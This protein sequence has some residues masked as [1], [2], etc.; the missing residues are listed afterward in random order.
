MNLALFASALVNIFGLCIVVGLIFMALDSPYI[1]LDAWMKRFAKFAVGGAACLA[2]II[3][4][5]GLLGIGGGASLMKATPESILEFA[6]GVLLLLAGMYI[7]EFVVAWLLG[8][9]QT[10]PGPALPFAPNQPQP[11]PAVTPAMPAGLAGILIFVL[12]VI[13]IVLILVLAERALFAGGLGIIPNFTGMHP[14]VR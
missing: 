8:G 6:I 3:Y 4:C 12:N 10:V 7:I 11:A 2:F 5:L 9:A 1:K 14:Q 13:V